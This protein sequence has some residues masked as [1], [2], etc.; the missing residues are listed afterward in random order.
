MFV[1][2]IFS[3]VHESTEEQG[4]LS[5]PILSIIFLIWLAVVTVIL[6]IL[7]IVIILFQRRSYT[8]TANATKVVVGGATPEAERRPSWIESMK[9][10]TYKDYSLE[11]V[12][13]DPDHSYHTNP[14]ITH[15][16]FSDDT[17]NHRKPTVNGQVM[18]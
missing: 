16:S 5:N 2:H 15:F 4:I 13:T 12:S 9:D 7:I 14:R 18:R 1:F 11:T 6:L 17:Y 8:A 3:V 10:D